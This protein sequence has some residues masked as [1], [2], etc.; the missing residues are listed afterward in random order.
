MRPI[1]VVLAHRDAVSAERLAAPMRKQF[2]NLA[3]AK[4]SEEISSAVGRLRVPFAVVDPGTHQHGGAEEAVF[5]VS[6]DGIRL[7]PPS[8]R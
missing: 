8:G 6:L 3:I 5:P 4:S 2:R 7:R 1:K